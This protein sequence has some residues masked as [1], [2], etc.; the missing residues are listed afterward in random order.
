MSAEL[1]VE[2]PRGP[3]L[4]I[5]VISVLVSI[6]SVT[7]VVVEQRHWSVANTHHTAIESTLTKQ[8]T[9]ISANQIAIAKSNAKLQHEAVV[10]GLE[11]NTARQLVLAELQSNRILIITLAKQLRADG[12]AVTVPPV[13]RSKL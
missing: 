12:I 8:Q 9:Q 11:L 2:P 4:I 3:W 5:A 1:R 7:T 10:I 13:P 6:A